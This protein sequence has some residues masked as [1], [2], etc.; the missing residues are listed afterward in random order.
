MKKDDEYVEVEYRKTNFQFISETV[1]RVVRAFAV[2]YMIVT[3]LL[4]YKNVRLAV[5][6]VLLCLGIIGASNLLLGKIRQGILNNKI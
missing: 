5:G 2:F 4:E 3:P 1:L 6:T